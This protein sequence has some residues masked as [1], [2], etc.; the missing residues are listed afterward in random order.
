MKIECHRPGFWAA[1]V[2]Y[3][4]TLLVSWGKYG[5]DPG[6]SKTV[7]QTVPRLKVDISTVS[8]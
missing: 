1:A 2:V 6:V 7:E 8:S 3:A 5:Q 4:C